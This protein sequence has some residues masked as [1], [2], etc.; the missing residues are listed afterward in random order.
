VPAVGRCLQ[1][2]RVADDD[3]SKDTAATKSSGSDGQ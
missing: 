3:E 2:D 1:M